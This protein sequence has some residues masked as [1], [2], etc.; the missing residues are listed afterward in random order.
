MRKNQG[1]KEIKQDVSAASEQ[2]QASDPFRSSASSIEDAFEEELSFGLASSR[3][4]PSEE[5][6]IRESSIQDSEEPA[7][8]KSAIQHPSQDPFDSEIELG[9]IDEAAP[10]RAAA[11]RRP[12]INFAAAYDEAQQSGALEGPDEAA[13]DHELAARARVERESETTA[14]SADDE[15]NTE[16]STS[17]EDLRTSNEPSESANEERDT[18]SSEASVETGVERKSTSRPPRS[19]IVRSVSSINPLEL[20]EIEAPTHSIQTPVPRVDDILPKR[21]SNDRRESE[22]RA[23]SSHAIRKTGQAKRNKTQS[24][25]S[26]GPS[27]L[28]QFFTARIAG[29]L[30]LTSAC[31]ELLLVLVWA[32]IPDGL[33][34]L[35]KAGFSGS[36]IAT[37]LTQIFLVLVP[38]VLIVS[39]RK[40]KWEQIIGQSEISFT[41]GLLSFMLGIPAGL[42]LHSANNILM[43]VLTRLDILVPEANLPG[44][45]IPDEIIA[46]PLLLIVTVL[47]PAVFEELMFRGIILPHM[48]SSGYQRSALVL[49]AIAFALFHD[50]PLFWLAPLGAGLILGFIRLKA[51]TLYSPILTHASMNLSILVVSRYLPAFSSQSIL[52][53]G[54]QSAE[55]FF[56]NLILLIIMG[57]LLMPLFV[58]LSR[59]TEDSVELF[60][61]DGQVKKNS[62]R[63]RVF[64]IEKN[65]EAT[66]FSKISHASLKQANPYTDVF[67]WLACIILLTYLLSNYFII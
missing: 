21:V 20:S 55:F 43:Y 11:I 15:R 65:T 25:P 53:M 44:I 30:L 17:S 56:A 41:L 36:I 49:S 35:D 22:S 57:L 33:Y 66:D 12:Q 7:L 8:R 34:G 51:D 60:E 40:I 14:A 47:A 58:L 48:A 32:S 18:P 29:L 52:A 62:S 42:F 9:S 45:I 28:K 6:A 27:T 38:S 4:Q 1:D 16:T 37:A 54:R 50:D 63:K 10:I 31:F 39:L 23:E 24:K 59:V 3:P 67:Y 2:K 13:G 5:P 26:H 61:E 46:W 19:R 64:F